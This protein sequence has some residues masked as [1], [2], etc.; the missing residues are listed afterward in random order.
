[1]TRTRSPVSV[2]SSRL[3]AFRATSITAVVLALAIPAQASLRNSAD[4][5]GLSLEELANI[6]VTSVSKRSEPLSSAPASIFVI[7]ERDIRR[8]GATSL[9]EA[10]RLAPNLQVARVDSRNYAI[11][12]RGFNNPFANKLLVLIDGRAVYTPLFS[13][14]FWDAQDVVLED[15]ERIEVIS[16]PGATMWGANAVN[17]VINVI[18]RSAADT[19]GGLASV[20]ASAHER[21]GVLRHGGTLDNGGHYRIY[22]KHAD[23]DD[24]ERADG[25]RVLTGW[26]RQKAGFRADWGDA[27]DGIKLQGDLYDGRLHQQGTADIRIS[28]A[29]LLGQI[30]RTLDDD[31][32]VNLQAYWDYT[33]RHQPGAFNEHLNTVDLEFRHAFDMGAAHHLMWGGGYRLAMDRVQNANAFAFLPESLDMHWANLFVQD[34]IALRDDLKLTAG[35]KLE[36]NSYTG[37][38]ALPTLRLAYQPSD[39]E[40]LWGSAS[41]SVRAPSRIDRDLYAPASPLIIGGVPRHIIAGG[42]EFDSEVAEVVEI[43]YRSQPSASLS[44]SLTAFH[45]FYDKLRTLERNPSGF[46]SIFGNL[47]KG[48]TRGIEMWGSW[49]ASSA[50]RLSGG[51]VVQNIDTSLK[52]GSTDTSG[53]TGLAPNDPSHYWTLRASH[54][55]SENQELDLTIRRVGALHESGLPAYTTADVRY[56]WDIRP[57]LEM[58]IVGQN[59]LDSAHPEFGTAP[60]RVEFERSI[61]VKL[62]WR[63]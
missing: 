21:S 23:Y 40:L 12:A 18:T 53:T 43:G 33:E 35:L 36:D 54:D 32:S 26:R 39:Q 55:I 27:A 46:D 25:T 3:P 57:D 9:P 24:V 52:P 48:K 22:G 29:N 10:L 4:L 49:Q 50:W 16:G 6:P 30:N 59:L 38:E 62:T 37:V 60:G 8:S 34:E 61:F 20:G 56:A 45:A 41:R 51:L 17:G 28:G 1:M 63:A 44:Y 19:Q 11:T 2:A 58:A 14:V 42:P 47:A 15:I 13:G 31:S 7:T 5:A